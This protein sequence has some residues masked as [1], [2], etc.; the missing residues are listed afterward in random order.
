MGYWSTKCFTAGEITC[1]VVGNLYRLTNFATSHFLRIPVPIQGCMFRHTSFYRTTSLPNINCTTRKMNFVNTFRR[2]M[3]KL[4]WWRRYLRHFG[5]RIE[6]RFDFLI[7]KNF[8][9]T[10][11]DSID[12]WKKCIRLLMINFRVRF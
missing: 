5:R 6:D 10:I 4:I 9:Y 7:S 1:V 3:S 12:I 8:S 2:G 11:S